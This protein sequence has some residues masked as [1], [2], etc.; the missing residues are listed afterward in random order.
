MTRYRLMK[1]AASLALVPASGCTATAAPPEP[2]LIAAT[3]ASLLDQIRCQQDPQVAKAVNAMLTN[4][5]IRYA[6][7]ESGIYAFTPTRPLTL[8][9]LKVSSISGFDF[10]AFEGAPRS[11]MVGTAPPVFLQ[12][13]VEASADE[14]RQRALDAGLTESERGEQR[15]FRIEPGGSDLAPRGSAVISGIQCFRLSPVE[16]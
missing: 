5:L 12:I 10:D 9:G 16:N 11:L 6:E 2:D 14:L 15:G 13:D 3:E 1:I 4:G 7:N 8:L